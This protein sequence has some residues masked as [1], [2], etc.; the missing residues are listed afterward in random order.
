MEKQCSR[1]ISSDLPDLLKTGNEKHSGAKY[2]GATLRHLVFSFALIL[3]LS[4][5]VF[6]SGNAKPVVGK[7]V[8]QRGLPVSGANIILKEQASGKVINIAADDKGQFF[9]GNIEAGDYQLSVSANGFIVSSRQLALNGDAGDLVLTLSAIGEA[10]SADN[11]TPLTPAEEVQQLRSKLAE[12]SQQLDKLSAMVQELQ[13]KVNKNQTEIATVSASTTAN[14]TAI[15]VASAAPKAQP[16]GGL[17]GR[18]A[19]QEG[20]KSTVDK[21]IA[22]KNQGGDFAGAEGLLKNDRVKVGGYGE[23]RY[24][25]RGVDD[26]FEIQENVDEA[27]A[28][29]I[30]TDNANFKRNGFTAPRLVISV[31]AALTER[32]LFNSE[33]EFEFAGAEIEVE[34][35]YLEYRFNKAFRFKGG[36]IVPPLGR[37]NIFHDGNLQDIAARPLEATLVIPSTYKDAGVGFLG[38]IDLGKRS[39]LSYEVAIVNGLRSDEGGEFEREIGLFESKGNNRFFD[40]NSQKSIVGRLMF[41]PILGIEAG[42]S[43]YRGKHDNMGQYDLSIAAFDFKVAKGPFQVLGEYSRAAIQRAPE[44][45]SEIA[46]KAFLQSLIAK[47]GDYTNTFDFLDANINEP[48]FDKSARSTDGFYVEARYRFTPKWFTSRTAEDGSIAPVFR[49]DQVNLDRQYPNFSFP[50][51]LRR[52]SMGLSV[53]PTEAAAFTFTYNID[54]KPDLF[55]RLPD[56]RPFPPYFTNSGVNSFV[57][58]MSY[59]F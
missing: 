15:A 1:T 29:I 13:A 53:R 24:A 25:T 58:G 18:P 14:T 59:A 21:L 55:L 6:A 20:E 26:G 41:S 7:V 30:G 35:A 37:F 5:S 50:L 49:F 40:N 38:D 51:N 56:G 11:N 42:F 28:D 57:F 4:F 39:K 31:A 36:I 2:R 48:I 16:F 32:L 34:Q 19:P 9:F 3:V 33:I 22:P 46:A 23:F 47:K 54:K 12:T 44:D 10:K 45:A 43:G 17:F 8:D 52:Y 27:N